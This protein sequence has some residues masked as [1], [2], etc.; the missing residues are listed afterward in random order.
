MV[1]RWICRWY[2]LAN[3]KVYVDE[4]LR[5]KKS[6]RLIRNLIVSWTR[7]KRGA[8]HCTFRLIKC[9]FIMKHALSFENRM[10]N[11][12]TL[13]S[14]WFRT[15][16]MHT[17]ANPQHTQSQLTNWLTISLTYCFREM[18][19]WEFTGMCAPSARTLQ[20]SIFVALL[21]AVLY[22]NCG[23]KMHF[24]VDAHL[25]WLQR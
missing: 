22:R 2:C 13:I 5:A 4:W 24:F 11:P 19:W 16:I 12:D 25:L 14:V 1:F 15:R 17:G 3:C 20:N 23:Q 10:N 18:Q 6:M 9:R 7:E 8:V 21:H